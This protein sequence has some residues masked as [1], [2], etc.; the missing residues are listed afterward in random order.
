MFQND[1]RREMDGLRPSPAAVERLNRMLEEGAP[2]RRPR[3]LG[4]RAAAALALCAA[5]CVT[6]VA[7]GPTLW[8]ALEARLGPYAPFAAEVEGETSGQGLRLELVKAVSDGYT[9]RVYYTLTDETGDRL[10]GHTH[11]S[12]RLEVDGE[13]LTGSGG[14]QVVS[15]DSES[16]TLLLEASA[17]GLDTSQAV[18]LEL[19]CVDP[20]ERYIRDARFQPPAAARA[21][22]TDTTGE[23][24]VVLSPGQTPQ[25]SPDTADFTISS[26][27]FDG[28]GRF[29]I[30]LAMA[31][32]FDAGWLLA[33]PY[34]AA[35][36]QMG[37]TLEQTAVDGGMDYTI[38]GVAP[39]DVADMASIRV[40]GAY[41]GPEAAIGGEWSLPVELEPAEQRVI[42]VGRTLE[43]GFYVE[44]IEVSGMNIAVYYRGGDKDWFVVWATDKSG[45]RTGVP[46]G[47]MSAGAED[48]L[49]LGLWSFETPAALDELAS[50]TLLG[51]TFPLE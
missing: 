8:D 10:N 15:Y 34:D 37:S 46:M 41:C 7:A 3:R 22:D 14:S 13:G 26:M 11:V 17:K 12:G 51:E 47:M 25:T 18:T 50:V 6:A 20:G 39:D 23:G 45:V 33:V 1:Y 30:R 38:G 16:R 27:G 28:Q 19:T 9:A 36:E 44:R 2:A 4:R 40:Y 21:L 29:H 5:L 42:P 24:A 49:N 32:G 48:G 31:E 35:G 43:G